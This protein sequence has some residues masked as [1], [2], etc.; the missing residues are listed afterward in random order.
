MHDASSATKSCGYDR[1]ESV[2]A[3]GDEPQ[4]IHQPLKDS[5]LLVMIAVADAHA[6]GMA[7]DLDRQKQKTQ[8]RRRQSRMF[9]LGCAGRLFPI[10]QQQPAVQVVGQHGQLKVNAVHGPV[11]GGMRSQPRIVVAISRIALITVI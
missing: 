3:I 7:P 1:C 6:S 8:S 4:A 2:D 10:E 11:L 5:F 9:H